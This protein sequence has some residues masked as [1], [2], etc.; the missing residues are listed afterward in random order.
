MMMTI[1][2]KIHGT[3][4][5]ILI[6]RKEDGELDLICGSRTKYIY[7][8]DDNFN[9]AGFVNSNKAEFIEKLGEGRHD[10][11][12]AGT[13]INS[14]E[15]LTGRFFVLFNHRRYDPENLPTRT[16]IV[17][18]LYTGPISTVAVYIAMEDLKTNGSKLCP[19]F[20]RPEGVVVSVGSERYK[21]VFDPEE[22]QWTKG[23]VKEKA[24]KKDHVDFNYL[25]QPVR[26]EKLLS[27][28]EKYVLEYPKS[29]GSIVKDY[30]QDLVDENQISG[31]ED[32]VKSIRKACTGQVFNFIKA[33]VGKQ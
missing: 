2:Q 8:H 5:H 31:T 20:M 6:F 24:P 10:G 7:P 9:F 13:G 26:L 14:G 23:G 21:N 27:R 18:V 28:D 25:C 30:I 19:G 4:A 17:P 16:V 3:N 12:W 32:E 33:T 22:T 15:G 29:L 11:E 1:T